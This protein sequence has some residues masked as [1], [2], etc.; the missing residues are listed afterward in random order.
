MIQV[1]PELNG[2]NFLVFFLDQFTR[3]LLVLPFS[4]FCKITFEMIIS[5]CMISM[6]RRITMQDFTLTAISAAEKFT[7]NV[8]C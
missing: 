8:N 7:L 2:T 6:L 5:R 4:V 3:S 1:N